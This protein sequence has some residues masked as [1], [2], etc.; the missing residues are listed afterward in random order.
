M[1]AAGAKPGTIA[2][3]TAFTLIFNT[4]G[5]AWYRWH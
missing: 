1:G 3:G 2:A 5:N 4:V